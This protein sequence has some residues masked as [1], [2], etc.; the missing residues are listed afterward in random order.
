MKLII[1]MLRKIAWWCWGASVFFVFIWVVF[2]DWIVDAVVVRVGGLLLLLFVGLCM[3]IGIYDCLKHKRYSVVSGYVMLFV[4]LVFF[5]SLVLNDVR[6]VYLASEVVCEEALFCLSQECAKDRESKRDGFVFS[7]FARISASERFT[8][9]RFSVTSGYTTV[10]ILYTG[11]YFG[12]YSNRITLRASRGVPIRE[13]GV[14][15]IAE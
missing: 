9:G 6:K 7:K 14:C 5:Y 10:M 4:A 2:D 11:N 15:Y 8:S 12:N 1:D 3:I 13:T